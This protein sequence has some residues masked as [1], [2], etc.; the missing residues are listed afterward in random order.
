MLDLG[1]PYCSYSHKYGKTDREKHGVFLSK[2]R[3]L[4]AQLSLAHSL[5]FT[6]P[7]LKENPTPLT[8][9]TFPALLLSAKPKQ[10]QDSIAGHCLQLVCAGNV[11]SNKCKTREGTL[12]HARSMPHSTQ[13]LRYGA[14]RRIPSGDAPPPSP[15]AESPEIS[16]RRRQGQT[17]CHKQQRSSAI[18][19][20]L[21]KHACR[22]QLKRLNTP[23][24]IVPQACPGSYCPR[25]PSCWDQLQASCSIS[26]CGT[27]GVKAA[28]AAQSS[29]SITKYLTLQHR[30]KE[31]N[32]T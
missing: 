4:A 26:C 29:F 11:H 31:P 6:P 19:S 2:Y 13:G 32:N 24:E 16:A 25:F 30:K 28:C 7:Q 21:N 10:R 9:T 17:H 20:V 3:T 23:P 27:C 12:L 8:C 15:Q 14:W 5:H 18:S 1:F 22:Q